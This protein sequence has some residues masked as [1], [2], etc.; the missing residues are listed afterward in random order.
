M[1]RENQRTKIAIFLVMLMILTPLASA[2]SVTDFSSGTN[3]VDVVL[4]DASTFTNI[5]DG[6]IDL[7]VGESITSASMAINSD[8]AIHGAH[9]RIDIETMPRVWNPNYNGQTTS[10]SKAEEFQFEDGSVSTPVSLKAEGILTDFE[11]DMAGFMDDTTPPLQSGAPWSHGSLFGGAILPANCASGSDCWGTGLYDNDY[12]NDNNGASFKE[13]LLSPT[14]DLSSGAIKDPSVY[15]DSFHQLMTLA[16]SGTNPTYRYADCAYIE[17]RTSPT[18][19]F[20]PAATWDHLDIDIQ[21]SSGLSFGSGYYQVG[22]QGSNNKIDGRCNGVQYNEY[23]LGG[24]SISG[25]NPSGWANIKLDLSTFAG[26]YIELRFVMEYNDVNAGNGYTIYNTTSM[27]GWYIDNFRFGS[28]LPQSGWMGVRNILPNVQGGEN[29]PNGYGLL[30]IEAETTTTAVL[31]V[32]IL[33]SLTGQTVMDNDGNAMSGLVGPIHELWGI[34]SSTYPTVDL[35]FNFDSGPEQLSTPVLHGFSIGSRVGTG[36]NQSIISP[37]PPENGIWASQGMGDLMM[38]N[39]LIPDHSFNPPQSR[40]HF[41]YPISSITPVVQDDCSESPEIAVSMNGFDV[42]M[43]NGVKY[44]LGETAGMPDAAFGFTSI[45]SYQNPC[46]VAGLWFDLEFAHHAEQVQIDVAND[47]DVEYAFTEPAFDMFGRQT[48]FISSKDANDVHYGT[49]NRTL[50]L[51]LSGTVDG[52]EFMLPQ[53]ATILAAEVSFE[54]NQIL[55]TTD[56]NEGFS[57]KLMSGLEEVDLGAIGN[58]TS[59]ADEMYPEEMNLTSALNTL[60]QSSLTPTA[61]IDANGNSW[62]KFR[63]SIESLNASSGATIDLIGLDVVY[64]VTHYLST[65]NNFAKELAQGVALSG[66]T[67]GSATVPI[68]VHA[69]SGGGVSFSSL[70]IITSP[71]YTSTAS[72]IGNPVGLYPNGEIYEIVTTHTVSSLT[73][74]SFQEASLIFESQTGTIELAYSDLNGFTEV[75]NSNGYITLQASSP[76]DIT[77]GKEITWRFT[78]N[79]VWED[80]QEVRIYAGQTA[81]NGVN[82]L[83]AAIVLAPAGGNAVENDAGITSFSVFNE[84]GVSQDLDAGNSN[85]YVRMTGS[86]RLESLD[87]SPDPLSYFTVVEERSINSSGEEPVFEWTEIANQ[88]GTIGGNFDWTMDLGPTTAGEHY[89]RFRMTGYEGGDTVCPVT[90]Y[91]PDDACAIPFNLTI[92]QFAPELVSVKVLNG[93]VDP[94]YESNWRSLVDDTWVIPSNNQYIKVGV[95]D[96]QDLPSTINLHYWVEYQHDVNSDGV[97]DENEYA[98]VALTGDGAYP[99]ANYTGNYN[100]LANQEKDPV[101]RVSMF[102]E[103]YDLAGNAIDG[104]SYGIFDDEVTYA[105]MPSRSPEILKFNIENSAGRPLLNSNHPSY[106]GDWNQTMY[107]GNEYHLIVEAEDRNGWRDLDYIKIELTNDR[108]DLTVYYFPRNETAWTDSPH[109]TIVPEGEDSD[110]PQLLRMDGD[111][112][113]NPFTDEFY[114]DL[115]IRINWGIVGL[116]SLASPVISIADLDGNDKRKIV[117]S[118]TEITQWYYSDGIRL[119]VRTDEANDLM[120]TPYF[121]DISPPTTVDVREGFVY[122][123]DTVAFEGQYAYIDGILDSV[124][125]L[126]EMELT[127]EVTRLEALPTTAGGVQ[128]FAYGAGGADGTKQDGQPTYHTFKGGAFNIN[129]TAP[130]STN[131]YSYQFRLVNL[132]DGALDTTDAACAT[133]TSFGCG[134]FV[135]KVDANAP[136]VRSNTWT[137]KDKAG[138]VLEQSVSTSNFDCLDISLQ[139]DEKEALFQGDVSVAWKF[140]VDPSSGFAWP[141]AHGSST[142]SSALG[143]D[144]LTASLTLTPVA[145]GYAASADCVNLWPDATPPSEDDI[146]GVDVIFWIVGSDSAGSPVLGGGPTSDEQ[147]APVAPIYSSEDRYNSQY[148]FIFEEAK[149]VVNEVDLLPRAPEVGD[150]MTLTIEVLNDGSKAGAATLRIQSVVEGGIPIT[151]KIVTTD[152]I[153]VEGELDV[154][155]E[156]ESFVDTTTGMYYLIFDDVT[157]ELLYNGSFSGDQFNVNLAS[158]SDDSGMLMLVIVILTGLILVMAIVGLVLVR[159]NNTDMDDYMYEDEGEGKAYASL[160]GQADAAPPANVSPEMAEA[161]KQFPQWSQAEIQGYF[162]QGWDVNSLQDWL[163]NQ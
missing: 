97:A 116:Q 74:A 43:Q 21:N 53:G 109:I 123:G 51:G 9:T 45:L 113:V 125:I 117:G 150:T 120:I 37:N 63:F 137:V 114:L 72:M 159:R 102:L 144:A 128:Y 48:L 40:S 153:A 105:S 106:E 15:F 17:I 141:L 158:E 65:A 131:E 160:P 22:N 157:G 24:T 2:A 99:T 33:D 101:G 121:S 47:G 87:V 85:R 29:H 61:H 130:T 147:N 13:V 81:D 56:P 55:S 132:P 5:V 119:D 112:L 52:G 25:F 91:R 110:G 62:K 35:K 124:Y 149:F 80:T 26:N 76:A 156:L 138:T 90:E 8:P 32:D 92:D 18:P 155:V 103:G 75:E 162:D 118:T 14:L 78:V 111:Y 19:I 95:T 142:G 73:G 44:T 1:P 6:S 3:E 163:D 161:M 46:N 115:P 20:D 93:Q 129:I 88:T 107:A 83:P 77:E 100:D 36:F 126:P 79:T 96:F 146:N 152:D 135:I 4:N 66:A 86:V 64:D 38:Y 84:E 108:D 10:F 31:S 133:S 154:E 98:T 139:I 145:G 58:L 39:P 143:P 57:W 70:S 50:T 12:T 134:E 7:P 127:L 140:Y 49:D 16:T 89:Y 59:G 71:G 68:A 34:N 28:T 27:P 60:M 41:S 82:G 23:A 151:E 94:N 30:T 42:M 136:A 148:S 122:P 69:A 104:G 54:N 67:S 11:S